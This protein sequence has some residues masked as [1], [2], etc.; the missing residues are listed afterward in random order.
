MHPLT[1]TI[2]PPICGGGK[3]KGENRLAPSPLP[4]PP[5]QLKTAERGAKK[6][7]PPI[8]DGE[9]K[10]EGGSMIL[11]ARLTPKSPKALASRDEK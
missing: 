2:S 1:H 9:D 5:I 10:I 3:E 4:K 8:P 11:V 7:Q 6:I